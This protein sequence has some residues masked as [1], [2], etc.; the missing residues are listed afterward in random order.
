MQNFYRDSKESPLGK[1][2]HYSLNP[3]SKLSRYTEDSQLN[4]DNNPAERA[5]KPFVVGRKKLAI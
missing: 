5:V 1:V 4:I 3:W 2:M